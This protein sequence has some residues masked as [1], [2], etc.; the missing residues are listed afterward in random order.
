[1]ADFETEIPE[2][3]QHELDELLAEHERSLRPVGLIAEQCFGV[4][5]ES[6]EEAWADQIAALTQRV[7]PRTLKPSTDALALVSRRQAW[8]FAI[9]PISIDGSA[10]TICTTRGRL[11]RAQRFAC[12]GI[13]VNLRFLLADPPALTEA[14]Q[15]AYPMAGAGEELLAA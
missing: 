1:M 15:Q 10:V 13:S 11:I 14:M 6:I 7:D 8:Q 5:P 3:I 9:L 4:A 2:E 12:R